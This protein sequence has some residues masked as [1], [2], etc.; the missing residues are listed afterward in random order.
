MPPKKKAKAKAKKPIYEFYDIEITKW[1]PHYSFGTN[2]DRK[3]QDAPYSEF[4]G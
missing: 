3:I 4:Y 2:S 1:S